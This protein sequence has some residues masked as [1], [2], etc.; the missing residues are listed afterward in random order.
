MRREQRIQAVEGLQH[1]PGPVRRRKNIQAQF[2]FAGDAY[3]YCRACGFI[4]HRTPVPHQ[5]SRIPRLKIAVPVLEDQSSLRSENPCDPSLQV[6]LFPVWIGE[7]KACT[8][9]DPHLTKS[10]WRKKYTTGY[11]VVELQ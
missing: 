2:T 7:Q 3:Y 4:D 8:T 11:S 10:V 5:P 6:P 9:P 1:Q